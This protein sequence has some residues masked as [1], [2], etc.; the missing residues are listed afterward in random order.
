MF[1]F[2]WIDDKV[3][4]SHRPTKDELEIYKTLGINTVVCLQMCDD[5]DT[6]V[7]GDYVTYTPLDVRNLGMD[8]IHI[9][10]I[11]QTAPTDEQFEAFVNIATD[12]ARKTVVHCHSGIGRTGCM[13]CAYLA[14]AYNLK[15]SEAID[16]LHTIYRPYI[17][18]SEQET[19]TIDWIN[20]NNGAKKK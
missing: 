9:P 20:R 10:V 13:I 15:S 11:D 5:A 7:R 3:A 12:P 18:T 2:R 8:L 1:N 14:V 16:R 6:I 4:G 17:A 19:K